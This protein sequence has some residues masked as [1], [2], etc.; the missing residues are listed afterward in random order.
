MFPGI[1]WFWKQ[2]VRTALAHIYYTQAPPSSYLPCAQ[3]ESSMVEEEEKEGRRVEEEEEGGG[4]RGGG[5]T[6][7]RVL[8][9]G[10]LFLHSASRL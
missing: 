9:P 1:S 8:S 4:G 6:L 2:L 7:S 5:R 10:Y 3:S